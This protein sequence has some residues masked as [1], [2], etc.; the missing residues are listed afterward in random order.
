MNI[1]WKRSLQTSLMTRMY[2]ALKT[3]KPAVERLIEAETAA[4][5]PGVDAFYKVR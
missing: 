2:S 3:D 5:K 1:V 4:S